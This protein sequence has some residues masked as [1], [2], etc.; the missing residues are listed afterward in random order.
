MVV[1][2]SFFGYGASAVQARSFAIVDVANQERRGGYVIV[3]FGEFLDA[4][5]L[6]FVYSTITDHDT[7]ICT[8]T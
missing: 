2:K 6:F 7:S 1:G 8:S 3:H 5:L 4:D